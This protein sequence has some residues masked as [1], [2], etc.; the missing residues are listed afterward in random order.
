[1]KRKLVVVNQE[2]FIIRFESLKF[3]IVFNSFGDAVPVFGSRIE[4]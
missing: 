3:F 1:M 2:F 4:Y